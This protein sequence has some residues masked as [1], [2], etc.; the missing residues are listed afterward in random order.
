ML[1]KRAPEEKMSSGVTRRRGKARRSSGPKFPSEW[2]SSKEAFQNVVW[3]FDHK[4]ISK[5]PEINTN[6]GLSGSIPRSPIYVNPS[7]Q[8]IPLNVRAATNQK[9][10]SSNNLEIT[11]ISRDF[12]S[13]FNSFDKLDGEN[14]SLWKGHM[15]DNLEMCEL[16]HIVTGIEQKPNNL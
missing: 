1:Q 2:A 8:G 5:R 6:T 10:G 7:I 11:T 4:N 3:S 9:F 13:L 14:L 16:W 15:Q 12:L